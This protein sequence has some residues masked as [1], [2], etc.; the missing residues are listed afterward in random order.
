MMVEPAVSLLSGWENF[1]VIVGSSAAALIGLQFVVIALINDTRTRPSPGTIDAFGTPT[2]MHL[3]GA[4]VISALMSAPWRSLGVISTALA[5]GGTGGLVYCVRVMMRARRQTGYQTVWE[6]WLWHVI[7]P[8]S[9]YGALAL[10][11]IGLHWS[12]AAPMF[13]IASAGLGLLLIAI[14]NAWD[15]VTYII[16]TAESSGTTTKD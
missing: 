10:G 14:H 1:Y 12:V 6:D 9:A 3:G 11:A 16:I 8:C 5:A 4:L 13:V 7:L 15:T 2:I